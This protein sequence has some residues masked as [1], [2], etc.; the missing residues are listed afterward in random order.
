MLIVPSTFFGLRENVLERAGSIVE[1]PSSNPL[2]IET[3]G[4]DL[5]YRKILFVNWSLP[6]MVD[7]DEIL[8][9]SIR[10]FITKSIEYVMGESK[11]V[12]FAIPDW[13][14]EEEILAEEMIEQ[15]INQIKSTALKVAFVFQPDQSTVY[16]RFLTTLEKVRQAENHFGEFHCP[17][18]SK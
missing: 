1:K 2:I 15:T 13:C 16:Q 4:G 5:N 7:N 8:S 6:V 17:I 10:L 3:T 12:V 14:E 9:E 11:S 18:T